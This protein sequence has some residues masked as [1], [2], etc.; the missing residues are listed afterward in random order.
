MK[1]K[2][3]YAKVV[4]TWFLLAA[5]M[6]LSI[7]PIFVTHAGVLKQPKDESPPVSESQDERMKKI[8]EHFQKLRADLMQSFGDE[9]LF[10]NFDRTGDSFFDLL[11]GKE[12]VG[13]DVYSLN[14][15]EEKD[16]RLLEITPKD[17]QT[18]LDISVKDGLIE[19]KGDRKTKEEGEQHFQFTQSVPGELDGDHSRITQE[20]D[21][22]VVIF[23]LR[24]KKAHTSK[25]EKRPLFH[26]DQDDVI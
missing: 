18:K 26:A 10:K 1:L 20:G 16:K 25:E 8:F 24:M 22:I 5:V 19:I 3:G 14:W 23:P 13:S 2:R 21:K 12:S 6:L 17:K 4:S 9:D 7:V 11:D 15:R